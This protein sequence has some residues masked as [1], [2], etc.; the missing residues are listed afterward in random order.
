[1]AWTKDWGTCP[2]CGRD[3]KL[4]KN[5]TL[6]HHGNG[7]T[8]LNSGQWGQACRGAGKPPIQATTR[9]NSEETSRG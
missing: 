2:E 5:R 7:V 1:M 3:Y 6:W 4:R 9:A 8:S